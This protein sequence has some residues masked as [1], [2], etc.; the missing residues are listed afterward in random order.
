MKAGLEYDR[1][2]VSHEIQFCEPIPTNSWNSGVL[3][4][5]RIP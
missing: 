3:P 4:G 5:L 1:I 2:S